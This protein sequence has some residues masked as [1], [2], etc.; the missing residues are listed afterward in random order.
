MYCKTCGKEVKENQAICT[1]CGFMSDQGDKFCSHC[2]SEVLPGQILCVKCGFMLNGEK[3]I[4]SKEIPQNEEKERRREKISHNNYK[5]HTEQVKKIKNISLITSIISIALILALIF[6][7]IFKSKYEITLESSLDD[8]Q[9][10]ENPDEIAELW[11]NGSVSKEKAFSL[12]DEFKI[13]AEECVFLFNDENKDKI[14]DDSLKSIINLLPLLTGMFLDF[15]II[16]AIVL[17]CISIS[18]ILKTHKELK[19]IDTTTLLAFNEVRKSGK[20][21]KKENFWKQQTAQTLIVFT[22]M[23]VIY[24]KLIFGGDLIDILASE[25]EVSKILENFPIR[26]MLNFSGL[27]SICAVLLIIIGAYFIF[28]SKKK[29]AEEELVVAISK[30][31]YGVIDLDLYE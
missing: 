24:T 11:S 16:E 21:T 13:F 15:I 14:S 4:E 7:P 22:V 18:Q 1:N 2:G 28:S 8:L 30:E 10:I 26:N 19:D 9:S 27:T 29:S 12:W 25:K 3:S 23:D 5:K 6:L 17:L 20:K 31:E